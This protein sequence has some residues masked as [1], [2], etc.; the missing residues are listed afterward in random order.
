MRQRDVMPANL[1]GAALAAELSDAFDHGEQSV[2]ARVAVRQAAAIGID[3]Q[4]ATR[5][6]AA[7]LHEGPAFALRAEAEILQE[8]DRRDGEGVV[9]ERYID[10]ARGYSGRSIG[11]RP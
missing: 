11:P 9:E 3:G 1:P 5:R 2:H 4:A 6:D 10:I 8:Q 7:V